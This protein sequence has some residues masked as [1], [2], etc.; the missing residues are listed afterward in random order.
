MGRAEISVVEA[1][2]APPVVMPAVIVVA[3]P[4]VLQN[5]ARAILT[6]VFAGTV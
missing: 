6:V 4:L 1:A 5:T 2:F 3:L